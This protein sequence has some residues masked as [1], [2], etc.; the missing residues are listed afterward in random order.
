MKISIIGTGNV[1]QTL[2]ASLADLGH[3]V[4]IGTRDVSKKLAE[5]DKDASGNPPFADWHKA[6]SKVKLD[7][8]P[9]AA[10]FGEI[11][12]NAV[13]GGSSLDALKMAGAS[14]LKGKILIDIANPLDFSKGMPPSLIP[15]LSNTWSLGEEIQKTFPETRVVKTLNTMWCGLMVNPALI[16]G[17]NHLNYLAGNDATAKEKVIELLQEFGWRKENLIDLGDITGARASESVLLIWVRLW[18]VLPHGPFNF[19]IVR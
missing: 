15:Q 16:G 4:I 1:G 10:S 9:N 8:F 18:G 11:V 7:T 17:G 5:V 3:E 13:H 12:I 6:Y 19:N 2:A 14:N